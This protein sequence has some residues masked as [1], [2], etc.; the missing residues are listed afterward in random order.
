MNYGLYIAASGA[1]VQL[2]RQE[3]FTNNLAN[4]NTTGFRSHVMAVQARNVARVEDHLSGADS[5]RM[6]ERLGGGVKPAPV[7]VSSGQG[8]LDTTGRALDAAIDGDGFFVVRV[9]AGDAGLRLTRDGRF[10][11]SP[12]GRL[13]TSGDGAEIQSVDGGAIELEPGS[14][15]SIRSDGTVEQNGTAIGQI[16]LADVADPSRLRSMGEGMFGSADGQALELREDPPTGRVV[17]GS[18]ENSSVDAINELMGATNA[19][20]EVENNLRMIGMIAENMQMAI[21]RFGR[22][23]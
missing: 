2:A 14:Q 10:A 21:S 12:D 7:L 1:S 5:N 15:F 17:Q 11:L 3:T 20:R 16:Q 9:G 4:V 13:V 6:L 8:A 22:V 19:S 18:V 23:S